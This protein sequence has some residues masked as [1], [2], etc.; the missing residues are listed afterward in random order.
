[1]SISALL[2]LAVVSLMAPKP[3]T[4]SL[5]PVA[6]P[7]VFVAPGFAKLEWYPSPNFDER[8]EGTIVDTIVLHHTAIASLEA[9]AKWF[10]DPAS[11]V[12]SHYTIGKDGSVLQHVSTFSRAWHAGVSRDIQGREHV[13]DFSIGIELV[14]AGDG[15]D[16][17]TEQQIEVVGYLIGAMRFRFPTLRYITS[18]EYVAMPPGRKPDP[19]G[20]PWKRLEYLGLKLVYGL[21]KPPAPAVQSFE[22][23]WTE[24]V[25]APISGS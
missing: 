2:S 11:R 13:N 3:A 14:N 12:S 5:W 23:L 22:Q 19:K 6:E 10:A 18:H 25:K 8:P 24:S 15:V 4:V 20:F 16:P 9:T 1:M 17:F 7:Q 21:Q